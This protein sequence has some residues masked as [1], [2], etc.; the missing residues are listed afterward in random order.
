[1]VTITFPASP[2][3]SSTLDFAAHDPLNPG[4]FT[5]PGCTSVPSAIILIQQGP[6]RTF[7]VN[8]MV[9]AGVSV[10]VGVAVTVGVAVGVTVGVAV[11]AGVAV[12]VGVKVGVGVAVASL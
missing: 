6:P 7:T 12:A 2:T 1:M 3:F 9:G 4:C 11:G 10:G 8:R 5:S